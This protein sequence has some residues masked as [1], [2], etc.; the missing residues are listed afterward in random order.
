MIPDLI[1]QFRIT[2]KVAVITGASRGIGE[3]IAIGLA[4]AG[5]HVVITA[6]DSERLQAVEES[7]K[8]RGG[9]CSVLVGDITEEETITQLINHAL[10][11]YGQ[12][13]IWVSNAGTS[14]HPGSFAFE[15]FPAWHWDQQ[16]ALNLRPHFVAARA[17]AE[18][19]EPGSSIIGI[20]S[21]AG[22]RP[23]VRFAAYGAAKAGMNNLTET[24][25]IELAPKGIRAN[26][27][28][29]GQVPTEATTRVGGV[30]PEEFKNL[31]QRIPIGRVGTPIDI[32]AAVL[33]LVSDA[34]SWVT[35]QNIVV[36]GGVT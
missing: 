33:Y 3:G 11:T 36:D 20:S 6:R 8:E 13:D 2:G 17:C 5:A 24:L 16:I 12:L 14:D 15:D 29:P 26:V 27:V 28:S 22:I 34:G 19:M 30:P 35:G 18:V 23:A 7:I 10:D 25:S 4:D 31:G 21:I 1:E 9:S 32:A